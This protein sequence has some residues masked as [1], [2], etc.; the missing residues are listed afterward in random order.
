MSCGLT[1][2]TERAASPKGE[3]SEG[4]PAVYSVTGARRG[5]P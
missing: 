4:R 5:C 1:S 3:E 2:A